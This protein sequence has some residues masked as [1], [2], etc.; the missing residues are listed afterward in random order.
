MSSGSTR[1]SRSGTPGGPLA[2]ETEVWPVWLTATAVL[3]ASVSGAAIVLHALGWLPMYFLIDV[4]GPVSLIVLLLLGIRARRVHAHV[5]LDR[6]VVGLWAGLVATLAYD[7]IRYPLWKSGLFTFNPFASHPLF[8]EL[9]TG[10]PAG[11]W[12]SF[13]VGW[14]YHFWNGFGFAVMYTLIAG[15][16]RWWY[17][18]IW[19]LLLEV[20]WLTALP[21]VTGLTIGGQSVAVSLIGHG[22]YGVVLGLLA[23]RFIPR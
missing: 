14:L 13:V 11:T 8:G 2:T 19:A 17:A 7:C 20:A 5:F 4:L 15:P 9:I 23:R 1:T 10:Y 12:T 21:S 6:L 18:V 16:A 22:V 3:C